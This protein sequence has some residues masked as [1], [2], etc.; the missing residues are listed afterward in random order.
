MR[1]DGE[2]G[3]ACGALDPP[4]GET[5]QAD[6]GIV[7]VTGQAPALAAA[8]LVYELKAEREDEGEDELDKRFGVA[9]ERKVGRLIVEVDGDRAV[10]ACRFGALS[11]VSSPCRWPLVRM[12]HRE[13]NVLKYQAYCV[14]LGASPLNPM[15]CGTSHNHHFRSEPT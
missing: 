9:Q 7:G 12:R 4:D 6:T 15:E 10:L 13:G 3:F 1:Q 8:G 11:H 14:R 2:H 5:T